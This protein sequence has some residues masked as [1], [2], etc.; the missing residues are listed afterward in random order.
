MSYRIEICHAN[1]LIKD[2][3]RTVDFVSDLSDL[4]QHLASPSFEWSPGLL[5]RCHSYVGIFGTEVCVDVSVRSQVMRDQL[6]ALMGP[7]KKLTK[8]YSYPEVWLKCTNGSDL[9]EGISPY[10]PRKLLIHA[11][12]LQA[13][14]WMEDIHDFRKSLKLVFDWTEDKISIS[15]IQN[16]YDASR[17]TRSQAE[18][19]LGIVILMGMILRNE[20]Q[21]H[22]AIYSFILQWSRNGNGD[23][24]DLQSRMADHLRAHIPFYIVARG[25]AP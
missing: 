22:E 18:T 1:D 17:R 21:S 2:D 3:W 24:D 20:N 13:Q 19:Y 14:Y 15:E 11:I 4:P 23:Y 5:V 6:F 8:V 9:A 10:V 25:I 12:C 16:A 7:T